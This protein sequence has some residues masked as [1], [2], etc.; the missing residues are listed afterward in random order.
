MPLNNHPNFRSSNQKRYSRS[1]PVQRQR[2]PNFQRAVRNFHVTPAERDV[3]RLLTDLRVQSARRSKPASSSQKR[4]QKRRE[5]PQGPKKK[6]NHAIQNFKREHP[7]VRRPTIKTATAPS[8]PTTTLDINLLQGM[9]EVLDKYYAMETDLYAESTPQVLAYYLFYV[10][11]A[12]FNA[13][14]IAANATGY[15]TNIDTLTLAV[16]YAWAKMLEYLSKYEKDGTSIS[17]KYSYSAGAYSILL[18]SI[19]GPALFPSNLLLGWKLCIQTGILFLCEL[20]TRLFLVC[21]IQKPL[22]FRTIWWALCLW[23]RLYR[24]LR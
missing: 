20:Q 5:A 10:A 24:M 15:P 3:F 16:P 21:Q 14:G 17:Y 4:Q 9:F 7:N 18:L 13:T 19:L 1:R 23:P 2:T 6:I 12:Y 11:I 22:F 8:A